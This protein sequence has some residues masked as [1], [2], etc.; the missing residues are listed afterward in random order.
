MPR[1]FAQIYNGTTDSGGACPCV[2]PPTVVASPGIQASRTVRIN[3]FAPICET[4]TMPPATGVT[5]TTPTSACTSPRTVIVGGGTV[6]I[7]GLVPAVVGNK[8][9]VT[10]NIT[11]MP[12]SQSA[13]VQVG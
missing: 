6:R 13:N 1:G 3:I 4:D 9:N 10:T 8:L 7:N 11:L 5:C 2:T 12:T